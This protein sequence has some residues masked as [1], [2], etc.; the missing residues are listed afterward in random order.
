[1]SGRESRCQ[2][3]AVVKFL[4]RELVIKSATSNNDISEVRESLLARER[5]PLATRA[6]VEFLKRK[7]ITK[8]S[9][10]ISQK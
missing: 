10:R 7:L 4:T 2:P 8:F 1:L 3:S 5:E 6:V 9:G